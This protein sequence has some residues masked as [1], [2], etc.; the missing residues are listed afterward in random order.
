MPFKNKIPGVI[1]V[2][3][4]LSLWCETFAAVDHIHF[5]SKNTPLE[6]LTIT[7]RGNYSHCRI[8]WG[9][10]TSYEQEKGAEIEGR[11]EFGDN[12]YYLFDYTFPV[13]EPSKVIHYS[14]QEYNAIYDC[15]A[16]TGEWTGDYTFQTP[17]HVKSEGFTFIAGGD[18]RGE[19][20]WLKMEGWQ[21]VAEALKNTNADFY[22]Y[23]GDLV[24]QGGD[25]QMWNTWY[26][27]GRNFLSQKP[28]YFSAGNH[29]T[30]GDPELYNYINQFVLPENGNFSELYYSFE[31]GN[32]VFINLDTNYDPS[33]EKGQAELREQN[34]WLKNQLIKYRGPG[35]KNYKEWVIV[36]FHKPFF[37]IDKHMGEMTGDKDCNT[38]PC[39]DF[40][41]TWWKD[42]FDNYGVDVIL[43][44]HT[45]LYMRSVPILL[46]GTGPSGKDITFDDKGLPSTPVKKVE[47]GNKKGQGRLQ[48]VTGGYGVHLLT[49]DKLK[50]KGQWYIAKDEQGNDIYGL[51]FHYCE[52]RV[53]GN[54]LDMTVKR[55][56]DGQIIDQVTIKH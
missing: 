54:V 53:A 30:Y 14:F 17:A 18:S 2:L 10:T 28:V 42:L 25:K 44:G 5:G 34:Q 41:R 49:E 35:T 33:S 40:T 22:L 8:R 16:Y 20:C 38:E 50:Y 29:E 56:P 9:Y 43:N 13:L 48:V 37:T 31:W 7:W 6:G 15:C 39:Y 21:K 26:E 55:I 47:Y 4:V 36:A 24:I 46:K 19:N 27:A 51:D 11:I 1:I 12:N 3:L 23:M 52:F 32:A 45:H